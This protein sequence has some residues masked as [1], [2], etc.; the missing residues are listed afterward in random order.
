MRYRNS[1]FRRAGLTLIEMLVAMALAVFLMAVLSEAFVVGLKSFRQLKA[2]GDMDEGLRTV[3]TVLRRDL[4]SNHYEGDLRTRDMMPG[5]ASNGFL[6][7]GEGFVTVGPSSF[8]G[9]SEG[10]DAYSIGVTRDTNDW[11]SFTIRQNGNRAQDYF[12]GSVPLGS[13]LDG[14]TAGYANS[15]FDVAPATY[16]S[17]WAEVTYFLRPDPMG[18]T[19]ETKDAVSASG[20]PLTPLP[21]FHLHRRQRLLVP[22]SFARGTI[23][24]TTSPSG[25]TLQTTPDT[26]IV[27]NNLLFATPPPRVPDFDVSTYQTATG[28]NRWRFV[29]PADVQFPVGLKVV[30]PGPTYQWDWGRRFRPITT[31]PIPGP[32]AFPEMV[33]YPSLQLLDPVRAGADLLLMNVISFDVKVWDP[34]ALGGTGAFVDLGFGV[35]NP[36]VGGPW[37]ATP[38]SL[39]NPRPLGAVPL[40][41][42]YTGGPLPVPNWHVTQRIYSNAWVYDTWTRRMGGGGTLN[43]SGWSFINPLAQQ[44]PY[45]TPL[46]AIQIQIRLWDRKTNQ[47]RQVTIT[48]DM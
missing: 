3:S 10:G 30:G 12:F 28:P 8:P 35:P 27:H 23:N 33:G 29:T 15:R 38:R 14:M 19:T 46:T 5:S 43:P 31:P 45:P 34:S 36:L 7:V 2:L 11:L 24:D 47:T 44:A 21:L 48:Q 42:A 25:T 13:P 4:G 9:T 32:G 41:L 17:Q 16:A 6:Q 26:D 37:I 20:T 39:A 22:D 40:N 1:R 18:L